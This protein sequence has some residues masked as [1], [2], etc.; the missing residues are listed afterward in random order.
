MGG[1]KKDPQESAKIWQSSSSTGSLEGQSLKG[2]IVPFLL[3][4]LFLE[5][6]IN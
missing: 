5:R 3:K 4:A 6:E 1:K 2:Q